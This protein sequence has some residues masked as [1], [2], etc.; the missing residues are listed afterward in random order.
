MDVL[1]K[2]HI[3]ALRQT[4]LSSCTQCAFLKAL[5]AFFLP[6]NA[7]IAPFTISTS[8][9]TVSQ[10]PAQAFHHLPL[11]EPAEKGLNVGTSHV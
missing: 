3:G 10:N 7:K 2:R 4:S 8:T 11:L 1:L 5:R 9:Q 6:P